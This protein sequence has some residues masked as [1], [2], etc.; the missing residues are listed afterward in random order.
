LVQDNPVVTLIP[1]ITTGWTQGASLRAW[2]AGAAADIDNFGRASHV[3]FTG[4]AVSWIGAAN[5][6]R[7]ALY[8]LTA[9][10]FAEIDLY[11]STEQIQADRFHGNRPRRREP[12][13]W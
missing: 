4:T 3:R 7:I 1:G 8:P 9:S 5:P 11:S 6:E 12:Q 10:S 2:S 13:H